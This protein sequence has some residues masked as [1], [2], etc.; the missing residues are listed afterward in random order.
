[1]NVVKRISK[2][3]PYV[4]SSRDYGDED[5]SYCDWN[6]SQFPP[7][8][9]VL[10]AIKDFLLNSNIEKYPCANNKELLGLLCDYTGLKTENIIIYNGSDDALKDVFLSFADQESKVVTYCPSYTQ[11]DTFIA[12]ATD[13]HHKQQIKDPL[14][15]HEYDFEILKN[16]DVAYL[17]NP[18]NPTGHVIEK[19]M[20]ERIISINPQTLF[21]I[22][23]AYYEFYQVSC[24]DLVSK[25]DNIIVTRTFSKAFGLASLRIG[26]ALGSKEKIAFL[27][28]IKNV[29]SVNSI[30]QV[31]AIACLQ[32]LNY[33]NKCV[34]E[35]KQARQLLQDYVDKSH[36][37][38]CVKS[39]SNFVLIR[40]DNSENVI[41]KMIDNKISIRDRSSFKNLENC[42]RIT[43][44]SIATTKKIIEVLED[45]K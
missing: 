32:D 31:A 8:P 14:G 21:I 7:S 4:P 5:W 38:S 23:E 39:H 13:N 33:L 44:G 6:E 24:A 22:D 37:L 20:I 26:Y 45:T 28:K 30:A 35:T 9:L 3:E 41:K 17:A 27:N 36:H 11:V 10:P 15:A 34:A 18:N 43:V 42:I 16:Y 12:M 40:T 25:Y 19:D 2:L 1:M 29:K